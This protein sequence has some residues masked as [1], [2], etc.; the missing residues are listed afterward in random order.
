MAK[1]ACKIIINGGYIA[2]SQSLEKILMHPLVRGVMISSEHADLLIQR[3]ADID[4][5]AYSGG[6]VPEGGLVGIMRELEEEGVF[7]PEI[8]NIY[9]RPEVNEKE[10]TDPTSR[11]HQRG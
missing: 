2:A 9:G 4:I 5:A 11:S 7:T 6:V 3:M 8:W 1:A 10:T